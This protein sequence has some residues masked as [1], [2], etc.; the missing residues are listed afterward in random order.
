M[1]A[2]GAG[3]A[4]ARFARAER[5]LVAPQR[6]LLFGTTPVFLDD[7]FRFLAKWSARLEDQLGQ[8]VHFIQRGSYQEITE[9]LL[10]DQLDAAWVCGYPYVRHADRMKLLAVPQYKGNPLYRSYLIV[11][12]SDP[13]IANITQLSGRIFAYSDPQSNSGYL[14]PR[15]E[16]IRHGIDPRSFFGKAFFT[17]AHRKVVEAVTSGLASAGEIDGYV[18]DTLAKQSPEVVEGVR[19]AWQ[20]PQYGFPPIVARRSLPLEVYAR[21]QMALLTMTEDTGG[22]ALLEQLNLDRFVIGQDSLFDGIRGL[23]KLSDTI[24]T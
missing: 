9:L 13:S 17:F 11:P 20:S 12:A 19:V 24:P 16:L 6:K 4:I 1:L 18:F 15:T 7:Q 10:A 14:V 2:A 5:S 8:G 3:L 23:V 21:L 22:R